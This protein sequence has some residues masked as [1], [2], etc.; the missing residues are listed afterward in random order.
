MTTKFK[1]LTP[2][3]NSAIDLILTKVDDNNKDKYME[4]IREN[5]FLVLVTH[6]KKTIRR[7]FKHQERFDK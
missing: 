5:T 4:R 6:E 7:E 3:I 1:E 2:T